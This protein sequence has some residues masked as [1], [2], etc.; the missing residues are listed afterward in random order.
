MRGSG[1]A[2]PCVVESR[3]THGGRAR[4][5][6][7]R[8]R[9]GGRP[10]T[11]GAAADPY[12]PATGGMRDTTDC[13]HTRA[14]TQ[15]RAG[16]GRRRERDGGRTDGADVDDRRAARR[17][18]TRAH[19][20]GGGGCPDFDMHAAALTKESACGSLRRRP[21]RA[22]EC[23]LPPKGGIEGQ[24][25]SRGRHTSNEGWSGAPIGPSAPRAGRSPRRGPW[26]PRLARSR[27]AGE[28]KAVR[29]VDGT[30]WRAATRGAA[31]KP[32]NLV[33]RLDFKA[34]GEGGRQ[35]LLA[36]TLG[37]ARELG[38]PDPP[39]AAHHLE[40][41]GPVG[42][43]HR[44]WLSV[45]AKTAETEVRLHLHHAGGAVGGPQ[46][47]LG[48]GPARLQGQGQRQPAAAAAGLSGMLSDWCATGPRV[49]AR[50]NRH[51]AVICRKVFC[52][53]PS[54][55]STSKKG[56]GSKA[57][58]DATCGMSDS[59]GSLL[60]RVPWRPAGHGRVPA[61]QPPCGSRVHGEVG[62]PQE[63]DGAISIASLF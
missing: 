38:R 31:A 19:R 60:S 63:A 11:G 40:P 56:D 14:G 28:S 12:R 10:Q 8:A 2:P 44:A 24:Q 62:A 23:S 26:R 54:P 15:D 30:W 57:V 22:P 49:C 3:R 59:I 45:R 41:A 37:C 17:N 16:G 5:A 52:R 6:G 50:K 4:T 61:G 9:G 35:V 42:G 7:R 20:R 21:S 13:A 18:G 27:H 58:H 25:G 46:A 53:L 33:T 32:N 48:G 47:S 1:W 29:V 55:P 43:D 39:L 36:A 34:V 51:T